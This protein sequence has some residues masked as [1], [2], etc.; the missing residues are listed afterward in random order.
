MT[1]LPSLPT[2]QARPPSL[3]CTPS[4]QPLGTASVQM[5]SYKKMSH[6]DELKF[7]VIKLKVLYTNK[8]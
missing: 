6:R 7:R 1:R 2:P 4:N 8:T 3:P 5:P